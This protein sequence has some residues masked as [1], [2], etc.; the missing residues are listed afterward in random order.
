MILKCGLQLFN[1]VN[2]VSEVILQPRQ[3]QQVI[4]T[5][6]PTEPLK[7]LSN[8][9]YEDNINQVRFVYLD[10]IHV[11]DYYSCHV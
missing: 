3:V 5:F 1:T 4:L 9:K 7:G 2:L 10:L 11:K 6:R 8:E